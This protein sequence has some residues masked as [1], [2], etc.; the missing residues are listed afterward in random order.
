M[1]IVKVFTHALKVF[2]QM[3][4]RFEEKTSIKNQVEKEKEDF[5]NMFR[6]VFEKEDEEITLANMFVRILKPKMIATIGE[7]LEDQIFSLTI[8][9]WSRFS[10]TW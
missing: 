9:C 5:W 2:D 7:Y 10:G 3:Q 6:S 1:V 8:N 4:V